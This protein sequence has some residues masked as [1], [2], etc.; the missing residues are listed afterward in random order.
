MEKKNTGLVV[1]IIILAVL[2]L[3]LGGYFCY[4]KFVIS[5]NNSSK[6][7][8]VNEKYKI[9]EEKVIELE[10][11]LKNSDSKNYI[12]FNEVKDIH[13]YSIGY[14]YIIIYAYKGELYQ[15]SPEDLDG[16]GLD[17][18][19]AWNVMLNFAMSENPTKAESDSGLKVEKLNIK[20]SEIEKVLIK[21]NLHASDASF[22]VYFIYKDGHVVLQDNY[23]LKKRK[24]ILKDYKVKDLRTKC[25]KYSSIAG[26]ETV[27][28]IL[29]LQDGSTKTTEK[30]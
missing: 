20:E 21:N 30:L 2:L 1:T 3:G 28:Y 22:N 13:I 24:T 4:D 16:D 6:L 27:Q 7:K 25:V 23:F 29:T 8:E 14:M 11:K 15:I 19:D 10:N 5:T 9:S 18:V 12:T 26:C 17:K